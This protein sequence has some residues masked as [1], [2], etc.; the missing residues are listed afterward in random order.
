MIGPHAHAD[1]SGSRARPTRQRHG[2]AK[3]SEPRTASHIPTPAGRAPTAGVCSARPPREERARQRWRTMETM[4][5]LQKQKKHLR[6]VMASNGTERPGRSLQDSNRHFRRRVE[7][8]MSPAGPLGTSH[9][10]MLVRAAGR[11]RLCLQPARW[12][13][14]AGPGAMCGKI[15]R[16]LQIRRQQPNG[17]LSEKNQAAQSPLEQA[18]G[19]LPHR[20]MTSTTSAKQD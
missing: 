11:R 14:G 13:A 19:L 18:A 15:R 1:A 7:G 3:R 16:H 2:R 20:C 9:P 10:L 5:M 12:R 17:N 4:E 8:E 6:R